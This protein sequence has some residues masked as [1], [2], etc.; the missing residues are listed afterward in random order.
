MAFLLFLNTIIINDIELNKIKNIIIAIIIAIIVP[1]I[2][3]SPQYY[4]LFKEIR[5]IYKEKKLRKQEEKLFEKKQKECEE[6]N[7]KSKKLIL[8]VPKN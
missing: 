1:I 2:L 3:Y 4:C 6:I 7:K 8:N 5:E